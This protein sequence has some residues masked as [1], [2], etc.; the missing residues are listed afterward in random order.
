VL[1]GLAEA[2]GE[3][4]AIDSDALG[5]EEL[6]A[7]VLELQR[8]RSALDAAATKL[9]AGWDSRKVWAPSGAKSGAA[10][11]AWRCR[12]PSGAAR[13][14]VHLGRECRHMPAAEAA[15]SRGDIDAAHVSL[16]SRARTARTEELFAKDEELLVELACK[17]RFS[18]F[19]KAL[20]YWCQLA[21]PD[22]AE[23]EAAAAFGRRRFHLSESLEGL[24]FGDVVLDA[25]GGSVLAKA[26]AP[27]EEELFEADWAEAKERL[28]RD[29]LAEELRRTPAQRRADALVELATRGASVPAGARRPAPLF[30]VLLD[31]HS[32]I[33]RVCE[34][35]DGTVVTPGSLVSWLPF[36]EVERVVFD[37]RAR[38]IEVSERKRL[39]EGALR[40]AIE[41]RD[42][43]CFHP[44]CEAD[45]EHCQVDHV[46]PWSEGG[47]TTQDNGRLACG[48][49]NRARHRRP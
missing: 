32:L 37:T 12:I 40:R 48:F 1:E 17:L 30:T 14:C 26:L 29:P 31:Y 44:S 35:A 39:F 42:R 43:G 25:I 4:G 38:V 20:A 45:P 15:W 22:G 10:Y 23:D 11:L 19:A 2:I 34:L 36:A 47:P 49:H 27:I 33:G 21:D 8:L 18:E 3:V 7:A 13:R 16:L 5:D 46:I 6:D 24:W 41:V 28:G 9:T